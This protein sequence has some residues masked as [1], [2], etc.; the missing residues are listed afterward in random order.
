[1]AVS[2]VAQLGLKL[3]SILKIKGDIESKF[4][5]LLRY[6]ADDS[7][8]TIYELLTAV[9]FMEK[10]YDVT[11]VSVDPPNKTPDLAIDMGG[12]NYFVECKRKARFAGYETNEA[13]KMLEAFAHIRKELI[14]EK[15]AGKIDLNLFWPSHEI[16]VHTIVGASMSAIRRKGAV[17][18]PWGSCSFTP[19]PQEIKVPLTRV[20]SPSFVKAVTGYDMEL[21]QNDGLILQ[22]LNTREFD[23]DLAAAPVAIAW[24]N[25]SNKSIDKKARAISSL[26]GKAISQFP[27]QSIG[28]PYI[29]YTENNGSRL[30]D[31]RTTNMMEDMQEWYHNASVLIPA[32]CVS[33]LY[34]MPDKHGNP[35]LIENSVE[36]RSSDLSAE[37][38]PDFPTCVFT[39]SLR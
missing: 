32:A 22:V 18:F 14:A 29:C 28:I 20:Y 36:F 1:M 5:E 6:P 33:R 34:A 25:F 35:D 10:G 24:T 2:Q 4:R 19:L 3:E 21:C 12:I 27:K 37:D 13:M 17:Y 15:L 31:L 38:L 16:A 23:V 30:A 7:D 11:I 39:K 9:A 8:N 26:F